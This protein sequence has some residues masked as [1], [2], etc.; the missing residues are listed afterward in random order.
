MWPFKRRK[1]EGTQPEQGA[2]CP[3]CHSDRT[4]VVTHHGTDEPAYVKTW[5][6]QRY[7]TC[8]CA[9]CGQDFYTDEQAGLVEQALTDRDT[10]D[11]EE[12]LREAEEDLRR[13]ADEEGDHRYH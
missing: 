12:A 1:N 11:D 10:V 7:L 2:V 9:N 5:R 8:H 4:K 6:G 3:S 13:R